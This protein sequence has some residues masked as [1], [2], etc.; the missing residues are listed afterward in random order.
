[1]AWRAGAVLALVALAFL[2][3]SSGK[4]QE[5][6]GEEQ[7]KKDVD[8]FAASTTKLPPS[9]KGPTFHLSHKYPEKKPKPTTDPPWV[10]ALGGKPISQDNA[11]AY[12]NALKDHIGKDM[13][14]LILDYAKWN[15]GAAG[16]YNM[17]W[18]FSIQ[19]PIHGTYV[20]SGF[21]RSMFP[22]SGLKKDMTTLVVVY[23]NDVAGYTLGQIWGKDAM[24]P[25]VRKAQ[26]Q[27]G[28]II[29]KVALTTATKEDWSPMEGAALWD[30]YAPPPGSPSG[31]RPAFFKGSFFQF[32]IIVKDSKTAP[33]TS[34][35][36]ST[37]VHDKNA[38]GD[39][40]DKMVP[41]GA[42]WGNDPDIN[43]AIDPN[44]ILQ[45]NVINPMGRS[46]R[47]RRS[48]TAVDCPA[49]TMAR[50]SRTR[51]S[52]GGSCLGWPCRVA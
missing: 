8:P 13:R 21:P 18:L 5:K 19:D 33:A 51:S 34:W 7:K 48:G 4:W 15:A 9:Y 30:L 28:A 52:T 41:L 3:P 45:Q 24:K 46:T 38:K 2:P 23:Y 31:T 25:D 49:P 11:I 10:K 29:V 17:P 26:Y 42:M 6:K 14:T 37:L 40:W 47:P 1:M 43:S 35:V 32:D 12:A 39:A 36:F 22:L 20:G 16:W 44:A 50:S 27:E